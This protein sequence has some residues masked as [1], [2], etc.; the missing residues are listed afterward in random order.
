[1]DKQIT[2]NAEE[3]IQAAEGFAADIKSKSANQK[4]KDRIEN[5]R[6]LTA[7]WYKLI[8]KDHHKDT[9]CHFFIRTQFSYDGELR[10][11]IEHYAYLA[12]DFDEGYS[13]YY[14]C[15]GGLERRIVEMIKDHKDNEN[16]NY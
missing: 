10:Y 13:T 7:E 6:K 4:T 5:V 3:M 14:D 9:D 2:F 11:G 15:L 8:S 12:E 1:M 16:R